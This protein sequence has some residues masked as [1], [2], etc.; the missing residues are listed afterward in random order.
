[1]AVYATDGNWRL[2]LT[3]GE[4]IAVL[5]NLGRSII[6]SKAPASDGLLNGVNAAT[7]VLADLFQ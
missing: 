5:L 6:E 2:S 1:M 3:D 4:T 7:G